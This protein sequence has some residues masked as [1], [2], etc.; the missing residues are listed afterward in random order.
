MDVPVSKNKS[1][2]YNTNHIN[3]LI[4]Y[5]YNL[6]FDNGIWKFDNF[7]IWD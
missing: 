1:D 3:Y 2:F 7:E 6:V 4:K 5:D